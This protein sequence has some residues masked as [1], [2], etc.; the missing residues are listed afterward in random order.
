MSV[1]YFELLKQ[2]AEIPIYGRARAHDA[3]SAPRKV[4][5]SGEGGVE[6]TF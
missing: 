3:V 2:A 1:A 4:G 6:S 5:R